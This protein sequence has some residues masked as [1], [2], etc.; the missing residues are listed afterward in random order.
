MGDPPSE[1][2]MWLSE[3]FD[4]TLRMILALIGVSK[5]SLMEVM[6]LANFIT[7]ALE[8]TKRLGSSILTGLCELLSLE[9]VLMGKP[10]LITLSDSHAFAGDVRREDT[11][12]G[13][14]RSEIRVAWGI[15]GLVGHSKRENYLANV[16]L[17]DKR[18]QLRAEAE[19]QEQ[20]NI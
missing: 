7:G 19:L 18:L 5:P 4:P 12:I 20:N 11:D 3:E 17:V 9:Q 6:K 10:G 2:R 13:V 16:A 8:R 15:G 1:S 14:Q